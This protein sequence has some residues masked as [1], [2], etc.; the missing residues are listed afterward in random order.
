MNEDWKNRFIEPS[1]VE[2]TTLERIGVILAIIIGVPL[3][4]YGY[5]KLGVFIGH[6]LSPYFPY[7]IWILG[8]IFGV[9]LYIL[10]GLR[11]I[12]VNIIAFIITGH[13]HGYYC[14]DGGQHNQDGWSPGDGGLSRWSSS[15]CTKC[16]K[17][18][19]DWLF[20]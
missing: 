3:V 8:W 19:D 20:D 17:S 7:M 11:L 10:C 14:I 15:W 1:K 13:H 9:Q 5:I 6:L 18:A 4:I 16:G 2:S 12:I